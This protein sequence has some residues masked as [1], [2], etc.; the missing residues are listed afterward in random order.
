MAV[1][2]ARALTKHFGGDVH[3]VEGVDL[4]LHAGETLG[5]VGESGC[6]KTTLAR[7]IIKLI[8]P[9]AGRIVL[10][11]SDITRFSRRQMR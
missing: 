7:T 10:N 11:G 8:E 1:V 3:A 9:T 2:E 5:L 4:T 6:G